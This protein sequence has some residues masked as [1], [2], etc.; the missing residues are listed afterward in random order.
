AAGYGFEQDGEAVSGGE[1]AQGVEG[2]GVVGAR[3]DGRAGGDGGAAGGGL[4]APGADGGGGGSDE[5]DAGGL[6]GGGEI[7]VLAEEAV[8]GVY[9]VG[10][11]AAGGVEDAVDAEVAFGR[12]AGADVGGLVGHADVEGGAVGVGEDSDAGDAHFA[13]RAY[14]ADGDLAAIGDQD[15][16]EH[17]DGIVA[18][19]EGGD[20]FS[21]VGETHHLR[22]CQTSGFCEDLCW[23]GDG[24]EVGVFRCRMTLSELCQRPCCQRTSS[25]RWR[26]CPTS[27]CPSWISTPARWKPYTENF[28]AG[29]RNAA[30]TKSRI[31]LPGRRKNGRSPSEL[32]SA[33]ASG[34][35]PPSPKFTGG[36]S[37]GTSR[38]RW[39]PSGLA[40]SCRG[41]STARVLSGISRTR[42]GATEWSRRGL[43][44]A[45]K[46]WWRWRATGAKR[47]TLSG[48]EGGFEPG[49][50]ETVSPM[51]LRNIAGRRVPTRGWDAD[52]RWSARRN[53]APRRGPRRDRQVRPRPWPAPGC[54]RWR[55]PRWGPPPR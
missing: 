9:G 38:I 7:G 51:I 40:R 10:A 14:D 3:D 50:L 27:F 49:Q 16:A 26:W 13:Q 30:T 43:R 4:G 46:L 55:W 36:R 54:C 29:L 24:C 31:C 42:F 32:S 22:R 6:A 28:W 53:S 20:G 33:I 1:V 35:F 8:A 37:C 45:P 18:G 44:S 41:H 47:I 11:V 19:R 15:L 17:A 2:D 25:M 52:R 5:G 48:G 23:G 34:S 12:G 21:P 39:G